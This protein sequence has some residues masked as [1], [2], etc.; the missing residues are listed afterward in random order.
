MTGDLDM[1]SKKILGLPDPKTSSEATSKQNLDRNLNI[2]IV[3]VAE[4]L[5]KTEAD[6]KKYV[7]ESHISSTLRPRNV[8]DYIMADVNESSSEERM[9]VHKIGS[10]ANS[11]HK[12]NKQV[13]YISLSKMNDK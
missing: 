6:L 7:N 13:Y 3:S 5:I 12:I 11:P 9:M 4:E 10:Y 8:F 1:N 2:K